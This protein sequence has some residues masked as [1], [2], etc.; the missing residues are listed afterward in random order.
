MKLSEYLHT[1]A[2]SRREFAAK[3]GITEAA[4]CRYISGVRMPRPQI[5][6]AIMTAS[7]GTV[8]PNDFIEICP[9]TETPAA[10][11]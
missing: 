11:E 3:V 2:I 9:E 6:R 8:T 5:A 10:A 4:L 1:N 7:G